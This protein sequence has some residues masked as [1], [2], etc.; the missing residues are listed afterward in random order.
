MKIY[1]L[2][3]DLMSGFQFK[4]WIIFEYINN[5][6]LIPMPR[7]D[8]ININEYKFE[9]KIAYISTNL[10]FQIKYYHHTSSKPLQVPVIDSPPL[11]VT[12][13]VF[14]IP[15]RPTSGIP[16]LGSMAKTIPS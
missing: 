15:T 12:R 9:T 2:P 11:A 3:N 4:I 16:F 1:R 13:N 5:D 7:R 8:Y 6:H 10:T 14:S